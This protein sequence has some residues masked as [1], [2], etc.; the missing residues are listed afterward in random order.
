M[1]LVP[2]TIAAVSAIAVPP[3]SAA[4]QAAYLRCWRHKEQLLNVLHEADD[5]L[6]DYADLRLE[7]AC[8]VELRQEVRA[9]VVRANAV[10]RAV[11]KVSAK[12][13]RLAAT[14]AGVL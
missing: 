13:E 1:P 11:R 3:P 5:R 9:R 2:L 7:S 8:I 14:R 12:R 6:V 4:G 10:L